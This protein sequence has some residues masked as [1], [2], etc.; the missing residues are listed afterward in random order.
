MD[1][2]SLDAG[3]HE[4]VVFCQDRDTGLRA[5]IAIHSTALG[6]SL[7]GTRLDLFPLRGRRAR[8]RPAPLARDDLQVVRRRTQPRRRQGRHHRRPSTDKSAAL[9]PRPTGVSSTPSTAATSR[10]RT[11]GR[12]DPDMDDRAVRQ[13]PHVTGFR[14]SSGSDD[15]SEATGW[16]LFSAIRRW[17]AA[18]VTRLAPGRH[19]AIQGVGKVGSYLADH[20]AEDGC[21]LTVAD[22]SKVGAAHRATHGAT[23]S[24]TEEIHTVDCDSS[25]V[26]APAS[27]T[28]TIPQLRCE[29]V[30]GCANNQLA[31]ARPIGSPSAG[32]STHRTSSSTPAA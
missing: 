18:L 30:A 22:A 24:R 28:H 29:A 31:I 27:S 25:P 20:L 13:T 14:R 19:V 4:Q 21:H 26:R 15:P 5:I 7:G 2:R 3:D 23:S 1:L 6:P 8:R 32:S 9:P 11:S 10:P 17:D 16:G 12:P